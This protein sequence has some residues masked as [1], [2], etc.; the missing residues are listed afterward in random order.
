MTDDAKTGRAVYPIDAARKMTPAY[1]A[2]EMRAQLRNQANDLKQLAI[3]LPDHEA[4]T[5]VLDYVIGALFGLMS[6]IDQGFLD[7]EGSWHTTYRPHFAQY[8]EYICETKPLHHLWLAGFYFNSGIQR[9][10][11]CFD[12]IPKLLQAS[13]SNVHER[14]KSVNKGKYDAWGKVYKEINA[15]K[16]DAEARA[17]GRTVTLEDS[18]Q[19]FRETVHLLVASKDHISQYY[20]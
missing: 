14:M 19:A 11:A 7:R 17:A 6:A 16:H 4:V 1:D 3:E 8:I 20:K 13:G 2:P 12:R 15:Y 10:A 5:D 9:I 18:V